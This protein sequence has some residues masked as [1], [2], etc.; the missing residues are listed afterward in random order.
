[1]NQQLHKEQWQMAIPIKLT[2]LDRGLQKGQAL[3]ETLVAA[4]VLLPL[5][6]LVMYVGKLQTVQQSTLAA[7]RALAFECQVSFNACS[8]FN[9]GATNSNLLADELRRRH[10]MNPSVGV[11]SNEFA[12][13]SASLSE[14]Q[15]LW[16]DHR[17][18]AL[19]ESYADIGFR[20]DPDVFNAGS[21]IVKGSGA[22]IATNALDVVSNLAGP[23]RFGL[24]WQGGLIDAKV[25]AL[26]SKNQQMNALVDS[27]GAMPLTMR[28][29]TAILTNAWNASSAVGSEGES[30]LSRVNQGKKLPLLEPVIDAMYLPARAFIKL[31][32]VLRV[33]GNAS[34]FQYHKV[35]PTIVPADRLEG[36]KAPTQ[37]PIEE[38]GVGG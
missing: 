34:S 32:E 22:K 16:K 30:T 21:G 17:G 13:D 36:Y 19:L 25:Q 10:F 33:E 6:L 7:S 38:V 27:L 29:H 5:L 35:D 11:N 3:V 1:L 12:S 15:I 4:I 28:A 8:Q 20:V 18:N 26:L 23:A 2:T 9:G 14:R 31:A 37:T 24:D